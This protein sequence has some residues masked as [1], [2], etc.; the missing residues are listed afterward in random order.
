[1]V[2][3]YLVPVEV[4]GNYRGPKYFPWGRDPDP[5]ALIQ[6]QWQARDYGDE[7]LMVVAADLDDTQDALLAS[8]ADV[9]KFAD[10]L[11][12]PLGANL[13]AMQ[14]AL[15]ALNL[16]AQM[17]TSSVTYR[18]TLR[19]VL[20]IFAIAQCMQG[21]GFDIFA[22]GITLST[23]MAQIPATPRNALEDCCVSLEFDISGVTGSTTVRQ[24]LTL[25]ANQAS[26]TPMLGVTI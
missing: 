18:Q 23:T 4:N 3:F 20:G 1:M 12:M 11:D 17:L 14:A 13:A 7:P 5:P 6:A 2:R 8:Q 24:L 9:T 26:P 16:P 19:G 22:G 25:I 10:D 15:E 21:K